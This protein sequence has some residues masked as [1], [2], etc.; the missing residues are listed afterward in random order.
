MTDT[1]IRAVREHFEN[2]SGDLQGIVQLKM[3][4][5]Q[6]ETPSSSSSAR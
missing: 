5:Q 2:D 1:R 6:Q 4:G 3:L